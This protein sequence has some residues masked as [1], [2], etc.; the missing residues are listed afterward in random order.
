MGRWR[1]C[2][3]FIFFYFLFKKKKRVQRGEKYEF[4]KKK[5]SHDDSWHESATQW[6]TQLKKND[7][8]NFVVVFF[9]QA[10]SSLSL[11][12]CS[13]FC[14]VSWHGHKKNNNQQ[15]EININKNISLSLSHCGLLFAMSF[16]VVTKKIIINKT[17]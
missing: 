8:L 15:N 14:H 9:L 1:N 10:E 11:S 7:F 6:A 2:F 13:S 17:K 3:F 4:W 12:L 5:S 16:G